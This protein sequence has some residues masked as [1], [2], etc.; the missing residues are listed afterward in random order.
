[1]KSRNWN[2]LRGKQNPQK[3][4][5]ECAPFKRNKDLPKMTKSYTGKTLDPEKPAYPCGLVG[6]YMFK[7]SFVVTEKGGAE[8]KQDKDGID[9]SFLDRK[10]KNHKDS[11]EIQYLDL[12][13]RKTI[14]L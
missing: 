9:L 12:E 1:M 2:Q 7:D 11:E 3:E 4:A 6:K 5:N 10:F 8:V 13:D 14:F